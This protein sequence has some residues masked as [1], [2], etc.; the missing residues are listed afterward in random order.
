MQ[1]GRLSQPL[2]AKMCNCGELRSDVLR[3][4]IKGGGRGIFDQMLEATA[5]VMNLNQGRL[6]ETRHMN[7]SG[8]ILGHF[9]WPRIKATKLVAPP[10]LRAQDA[11]LADR[12]ARGRVVRKN[13]P[14]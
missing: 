10:A 13:L 8:R 14:I 9:K 2:L 11:T 1:S 7:A 12:N 4:G 6:L 3:E 5:A